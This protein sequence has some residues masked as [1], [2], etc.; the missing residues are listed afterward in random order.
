M[1]EQKQRKKTKMR[2]QDKLLFTKWG[3]CWWPHG[4]IDEACN[5]T[6]EE[7]LEVDELR[8]APTAATLVALPRFLRKRVQVDYVLPD[9]RPAN[10]I[11]C[12][13]QMVILRLCHDRW[14]SRQKALGQYRAEH[15]IWIK[16][17]RQRGHRRFERDENDEERNGGDGQR[18]TALSEDE[19]DASQRRIDEIWRPAE[20]GN[21]E[22]E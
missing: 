21:G 11:L 14:T 4:E 6:D 3:P 13:L 7:R 1:C 22:D 19:V 17:R 5:L 12:E 18:P 15:Q 8:R 9:H 10:D 2:Q 16:P 20:R